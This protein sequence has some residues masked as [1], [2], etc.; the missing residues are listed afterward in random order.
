M[1]EK[2]R[3]TRSTA[4][5]HRQD[6]G[7]QGIERAKVADAFDAGQAAQFLNRAVG[8]NARRLVEN[9]NTVHQGLFYK[10]SEIAPGKLMQS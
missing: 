7:T 3:Q 6:T 10:L 1:R 8:G 4:H 9:E 5:D 2:L